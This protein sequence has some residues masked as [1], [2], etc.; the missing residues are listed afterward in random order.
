MTAL[1]TLRT[2]AE[3]LR[4]EN[5]PRSTVVADWLDTTARAADICIAKWRRNG[6]NVPE[7]INIV[8]PPPTERGPD[9]AGGN[10]MKP[11]EGSWYAAHESLPRPMAHVVWVTA[12]D[13]ALTHCLGTLRVAPLRPQTTTDLVCPDCWHAVNDVWAVLP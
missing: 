8:I 13:S 11:V 1:E 3:S 4:A 6:E 12:D 5:T 9:R 10:H 7:L 2:A